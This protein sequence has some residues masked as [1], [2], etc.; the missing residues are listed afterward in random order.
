MER[1]AFQRTV[2]TLLNEVKLVEVCTDAHV[3]I[4]AL[5]NKG[6]YKDLGLQHSLDMWHGAKNLAKR[7]YAASQVKGQSSLSSWLKDVVN[8]FWW[9]CKTAD[10]YQEFLELWLGLLHHVTNEHRWV[11]GGCQHAD[12]ESGGAQQWLERG[13]MAHEA[14]KSIV[15]NKRWLNEVYC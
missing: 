8:H 10:S 4:S 13:S 7:I 15:R 14:L 11:L 6:K 12:L 5:M 9:C 1:E 3:Q 2:D